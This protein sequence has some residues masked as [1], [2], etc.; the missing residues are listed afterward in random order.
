MFTNVKHVLT[1][2]FMIKIKMPVLSK[3]KNVKKDMFIMRIL[4]SVSVHMK[5]HLIMETNVS[6]VI[7]LNT[8]ISIV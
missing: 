2:R 3:W 1:V 7:Y 6:L 4:K 5:L 8:G